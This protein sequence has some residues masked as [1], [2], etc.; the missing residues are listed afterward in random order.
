MS[1]ATRAAGRRAQYSNPA[2]MQAAAGPAAGP[3]CRLSTITGSHSG[4]GYEPVVEAARIC[5]AATAIANNSA[6]STTM[7]NAD[8]QRDA[9]GASGSADVDAAVESAAASLI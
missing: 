3:C 2:T 9:W 1:S 7:R 4:L 6:N 8:A 5:F